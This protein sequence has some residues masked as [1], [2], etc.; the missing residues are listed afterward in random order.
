MLALHGRCSS[1]DNIFKS[2]IFSH[3]MLVDMQIAQA[4][5]TAADPEANRSLPQLQYQ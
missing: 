1:L 4:A 3:D 2:Y 5:M